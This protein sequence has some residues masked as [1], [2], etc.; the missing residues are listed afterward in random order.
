MY[1]IT[2]YVTELRSFIELSLP[3]GPSSKSH[4]TLATLSNLRR[5]SACANGWTCNSTL[6]TRGAY[7]RRTST[8]S[9][10][11]GASSRSK[12]WRATR[13][14]GR[15]FAQTPPSYARGRRPTSGCVCLHHVMSPPLLP[16]SLSLSLFA[17]LYSDVLTESTHTTN[18]AASRR[19]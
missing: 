11:S 3:A 17:L 4:R 1:Y 16:G 10:R 14:G 15:N 19:A 9:M 6:Y 18:A 2:L 8:R 7:S 13:Y 12:R 5:S